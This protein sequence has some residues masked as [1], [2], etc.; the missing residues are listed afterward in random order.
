MSARSRSAALG[1]LVARHPWRV[2][3][4]SLA[5]TALALIPA[6]RFRLE[7]DLTAL[8][9]A[10][11]PAAKEY[12]EF[13]ETFGGFEKV[14]VVVQAAGPGPAGAG[15]DPSL[16]GSALA[17]AAEALA[18]GLAEAPAVA[19]ARSG[20]TPD[21]EAF[22]L[23]EVAPRAPLF[24]AADAAGRAELARRLRPEEIRRRVAGLRQ[25]LRS[26][27][28]SFAA[29]FL[30][31]DPLGLAEGFLARSRGALP[32]DPLTGAFLSRDGDAALVV[33]TPA[34]AEIDPAGGRAL[35]A[36]VDRALPAAERAGGLRL[37]LTPLGGAVY[38][39]HD[40]SIIKADVI[41]LLLGSVLAV[42]FLLLV[43]FEGWFL[44]AALS[45][46]VL[47]G[48]VWT[49]G[50]LTL[51]SG[52][53][54][55]VGLCFVA[56]LFGMG[57]EYGIHGGA[58]FRQL[59][60][61]GETAE[62]ALIGA[63]RDAGPAV[64]STA[65]TTA[66]ALGALVFAHFRPLR[67]LGTVLG[68]GVLAIL[69]STMTLGAALLVLAPR[70]TAPRGGSLWRRFW[71]PLFAGLTG[72][73]ARRPRLVLGLALLATAAAA[74]GLPRL[75]LDVDLRALRPA[76]HPAAAA[77][78]LVIEEFGIGL[79]ASTVVVR[80]P[81]LA[82]AL[83]AADRVRT[84]LAG[85]LADL[86]GSGPGNG[87]EATSTITSP[88]DW[89]VAGERLRRRRAALAG[90]P[91][92]AAAD[93]LERELA[94]AGFRPEPFARAV[95]LL[96]A[97]DAGHPGGGDD[98]GLPPPAAWPHGL[99]ELVRLAPDGGAAVA[100]YVETPIGGW[101]AGPPPAVLAA[102]ERAAPGAAFASAPRVGAEL[103]DLAL[104][105]LRRSSVLAAVL[106]AGVVVV[107]LGGGSG[108][109]GALGALGA[110]LLAFLPLV[111]GCVWTFGFL[112]LA[113][114][115][116]D[117]LSIATLPV[118]FGTGIDLGVHAVHG[119]RQEGG[120]RRWLPGLRGAVARSGLAMTL[121]I[122]TTG[123]GFGSLGGS[124]VPGIQNAGLV[125]AAGVTACLLAT[126]FVLPALGSLQG[127]GSGRGRTAGPP[128]DAPARKES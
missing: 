89:M 102:V 7:T 66:V 54:T 60:L 62:E 69:G 40:E 61:A 125:V 64:L 93:Q 47:A 124:R 32:V 96:R 29:P 123:A 76:D 37:R 22:F 27:G 2:L 45:A 10:D 119:A 53:L 98:L 51:G 92:A 80:G 84:V 128:A 5:V 41:R 38:A 117:L 109:I 65:L 1:A 12:R 55:V 83:D 58:R 67:E 36:A 42:A 121:I 74:A 28:G 81:D 52:R 105:D 85:A 91:L 39:A 20:L 25:T 59:R 120:G 21:E 16:L 86:P 19:A 99:A 94:A 72:F 113:G 108:G 43:G 110:S 46:A 6:S 87:T 82:A 97:L 50:L 107:S 78:R 24:L 30:A 79:D 118:L 48:V 77:E 63:F 75:R 126:L 49:A 11:A 114:R 70:A 31:A 103:R 71:D 106:V 112:G 101:P 44:P 34:S 33:V 26:P 88:S 23:E 100:V 57:A 13:L 18:A 122:L 15:D 115:S 14:F 68:V 73:A 111:L 17:D 9:P 4:F 56:A 95:G 8:L 127:A 116:L 35:L 3:G 104:S 90:L